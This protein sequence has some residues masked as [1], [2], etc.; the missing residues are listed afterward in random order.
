MKDAHLPYV[1]VLPLLPRLAGHPGRR[2]LEGSLQTSGMFSHCRAPPRCPS[3]S[4][5]WSSLLSEGPLRTARPSTTQ[6]CGDK[7]SR[8]GKNSEHHTANNWRSEKDS[9][10]FSR[11]APERHVTPSSPNSRFILPSGMTIP[12]HDNPFSQSRW[13][14]CRQ[15]D[16]QNAAPKKLTFSMPQ[17]SHL[18]PLFPLCH[19]YSLPSPE[20]VSQRSVCSAGAR[21][22]FTSHTGCLSESSALTQHSREHQQGAEVS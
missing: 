5:T 18:L 16:Q 1:P 2:A 12:R 15:G 9:A 22:S 21:H 4:W 3:C 14:C 17:L 11:E 8:G 13:D 19:Q 10:D 20:E 7:Q 6:G